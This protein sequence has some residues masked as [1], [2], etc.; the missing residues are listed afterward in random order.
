MQYSLKVGN[1]F[2]KG[3][4][5]ALLLGDA[6]KILKQI[7]DGYVDHCVTD[8]PYNIS[9]YDHKKNIGWLNSNQ[10]W[11]DTKKF[12]KIEEGWDKFSNHDYLYFTEQWLTEIVRILKPNVNIIVFGSYHN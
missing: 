11:N 4:P 3:G 2:V 10:Y 8:P 12:K 7:P 5:S 9:G 1:R 6:I